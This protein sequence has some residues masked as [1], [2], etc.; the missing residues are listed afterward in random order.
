MLHPPSPHHIAGL[1]FYLNCLQ[2]LLQLLSSQA[3]FS[4]LHL[5][6]PIHIR[7]RVKMRWLPWVPC[8]CNSTHKVLH[9]SIQALPF[10]F[11]AVGCHPGCRWKMVDSMSARKHKTQ[12]RCEL[13][14]VSTQTLPF[15]KINQNL[16]PRQ[17]QA[18]KT[19]HGSQ[20]SCG[21]CSCST[22][23]CNSP[24]SVNQMI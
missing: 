24:C 12:R 8:I 22:L 9:C 1:G 6:S 2:L 3:R 11:L 10:S 5:Y 17:S 21:T 15:E 23:Q 16:S 7:F 4:R 14:I 20:C 13:E 18:L 19:H